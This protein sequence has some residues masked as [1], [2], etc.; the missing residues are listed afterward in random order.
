MTIVDGAKLQNA[1]LNLAITARDAMPLGGQLAVEASPVRRDADYAQSCPRGSD[2]PVRA[3]RRHRH[4]RGHV[5]GGAPARL[6]AVLLERAVGAGT[7]LGLSMVYGFVKQPGGHI[8]IYSE[9]GRG[10]RSRGRFPFGLCG[11]GARQPRAEKGRMARDARYR[12]RAGRNADAASSGGDGRRPTVARAAR[13]AY[14][15][16]AFLPIRLLEARSPAATASASHI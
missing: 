13:R 16:C 15:C 14:C 4:G 3:D 1:L 7:G 5:G 2:R 8:Q 12:R 6:R 9:I 10:T 11:A